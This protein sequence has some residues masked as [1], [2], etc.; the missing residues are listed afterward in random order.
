MR[1]RPRAKGGRRE[2]G[3][4]TESGTCVAIRN[5]EREGKEERGEKEGGGKEGR[6]EG[7][8][9]GRE[10]R[11]GKRKGRRPAERSHSVSVYR[12]VRSDDRC[13]PV[14]TLQSAGR[15]PFDRDFPRCCDDETRVAASVRVLP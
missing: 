11:G 2:R 13:L 12:T 7:R 4:R 8:K 1:A 9:E 3:D 10:E 6:A 15:D 14:E 5:G